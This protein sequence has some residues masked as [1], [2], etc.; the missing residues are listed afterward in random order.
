MLGAWPSPAAAMDAKKSCLYVEVE[1]TE[2]FTQILNKRI[3]ADF[4]L[5]L[6]EEVLSKS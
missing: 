5:S 3:S 2:F 6:F 1:A 4:D